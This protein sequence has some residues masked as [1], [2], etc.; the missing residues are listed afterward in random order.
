LVQRRK[1]NCHTP[2]F[3]LHS[4]PVFGRQKRKKPPATRKGPEWHQCRCY[5][6]VGYGAERNWEVVTQTSS[7]ARELFRNARIHVPD[8]C[9]LA[10]PA[11][12]MQSQHLF[13]AD[14]PND[15]QRRLTMQGSNA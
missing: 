10:S 11:L 7:A 3:T 14:G 4:F 15:A 8:D 6:R 9:V 2:P 13:Y 5:G 12:S 1:A